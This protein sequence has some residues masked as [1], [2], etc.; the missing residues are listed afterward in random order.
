MTIELTEQFKE[1]F[2]LMEKTQDNLFITGKAG[3]GKST[4]L[5]YFRDNT[6]KNVVVL[7]PTG[8]AAVNIQGETIHSFFGFGPDIS[9][10]NIGKSL[11]RKKGKVYKQVE[12]IVIDE[13]SMVRADL[14]DY[15]DLFLKAKLKNEMPFGGK[16]V[17]FFG[18]LYQLPPV[19]TR[20]DEMVFK[21]VYSSPYFFSSD[22]M[23]EVDMKIIELKKIFR[24][25]DQDFISILNRI[26]TNE[27]QPEDVDKLND[28]VG[29]FEPEEY[30][31]NMVVYLTT[32]N[33]I[34]DKIN[35]TQL[36]KL[37]DREY[38]FMADHSPGIN[39]RQF[40]TEPELNVKVGSQIMMLNN[41]KDGRWINGTLGQ[42]ANIIPSRKIIEIQLEDGKLVEVEQHN[43]DLYKY[44]F[45]E[46]SGQVESV[47]V[48]YF[49]QFPFKLAWAITI[50]K[51][52]GKTFNKA[53]ID[54]GYG[55][56]AYGQAYVALSRVVSLEGLRLKRPIKME[57]VFVDPRIKIFFREENK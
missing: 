43:W 38:K 27:I 53:F 45:N 36:D 47:P 22:V 12:T 48:G 2:N 49:K 28:Y 29:Y 56:F 10:K 5:R 30:D 24:Q 3:S 14:L 39:L 9:R 41:E 1:A 26:R 8:V 55:T 33:K 7:A 4:L 16:Q 32:T 37:E 51:S 25:Q 40:P 44:Q 20:D 35:I 42:V 46:N 57:D 50:H 34:A 31:S 18:D 19:V 52:Q 17:I 13:I 54:F 6:K 11:R 21:T 15:V 23:R